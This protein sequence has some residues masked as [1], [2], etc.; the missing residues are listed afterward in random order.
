MAVIRLRKVG[1]GVKKRKEEGVMWSLGW[2]IR[3]V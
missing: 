3:V 1:V 2:V